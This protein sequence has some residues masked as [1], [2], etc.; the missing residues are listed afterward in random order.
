MYHGMSTKLVYDLGERFCTS[1]SS[2]EL[3][4]I[5]LQTVAADREWN[6]LV[7]SAERLELLDSV[8]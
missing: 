8:G 3:A 4:E 2:D 7:L 5:E 1:V 6:A